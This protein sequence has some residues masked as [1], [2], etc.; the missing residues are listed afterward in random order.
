[1]LVLLFF[2]MRV[3]FLLCQYGSV[4]KRGFLLLEIGGIGILW[5]LLW[6]ILYFVIKRK[7][8]YQGLV[9]YITTIVLLSELLAA[10]ATCGFWGYKIYQSAIPYN[11]KLAWYIH[12]KTSTRTI[13]LR[14]N[15]FA[16]TGVDGILKDLNDKLTLPKELYLANYF[17]V[18]V[19][20]SGKIESIYTFLYGKDKNGKT[21]SYLVDYNAA[22]SDKMTVWL[23]GESNATYQSQEKLQPMQDMISA[24]MKENK[25]AAYIDWTAAKD[26]SYTFTYKGY[27]SKEIGADK[28]LL[29]S[30]NTSKVN[31]KEN[32]DLQDQTIDGY[33]VSVLKDKNSLF[34]LGTG[35]ETNQTNSKQQTKNQ[36]TSTYKAGETKVDEEGTMHY[37]LDDKTQMLLKVIDAAAG[38]RSYSFTGPKG[39]NES[40]FGNEIGV[41]EG[42]YFINN[43]IGFLGLSSASADDSSLYATTD[44][45]IS[46]QK[47]TFPVQDGESALINHPYGYTSKDFN[48]VGIPYMQDHNLYVKIGTDA[49]ELN[50]EYMLFES[51]DEGMTWKYVSYKRA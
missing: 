43:E 44:G 5:F 49:N 34:L 24:L 38:S 40:P 14:H 27:V 42:M 13:T 23:D 2:G 33:F 30:D 12:D 11:G 48:Y 19:D 46:F 7:I 21:R 1:M 22:K 32:L 17:Q 25:S 15:D 47:V 50:V 6:T 45:G 20:H 37:Y 36:D 8:H 10:F 4:R 28:V 35:L 16:K 29:Y 39:V 31:L 9:K 41:A 26:T 3:L 51:E 18:K